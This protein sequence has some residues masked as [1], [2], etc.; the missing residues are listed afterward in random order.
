MPFSPT[1]AGT[2]SRR[3]LVQGVGA[4][5][6]LLTLAGCRSAVDD[7]KVA[8]AAGDGVPG[9]GGTLRV[10]ALIDHT[11]GLL[12]T[13]GSGFSLHRLIF[14]TLTRY[15]PGTL[16]PQPQLATAWRISPDGTEVKLTL[17]QGVTF[18]NGRPFTAD[19][20]V[21]AI[22]NLQNPQRSAQLR[23]TALAITGFD[24]VSPHELTLR[25][26]HPVANL[27]D[28][29]EF[30]IIAAKESVDGALQGG[31]PIGTGAFVWKS[32]TPGTSLTLDR[33]PNYWIPERPYLDGVEIRV[34]PQPDALLAALR[35]GQAHMSYGLGGRDL[36]SIE[37]D[38]AFVLQ[39][40]DQGAGNVYVGVNTAVAPFGDKRIRQA[41]SYAI[42]RD[43]IVKQALGGYGLAA[44]TPWPKSSP[45]F[46]EADAQR[47]PH[48]PARAKA[49]LA[50]AGHGNGLNVPLAYLGMQSAVAQM[51]QFDLDRIGV[52]TTLE[53]LDAAKFQAQ[54]IAQSMPALWV[55]THGFAANQPSTLAVSAYPFN[56]ARNTSKFS[57]PK[58]TEVVQRAWNQT[59]A[60][61]AAAKAAYTELGQVLLDEQFIIDIAVLSNV[62]PMATA[63]RDVTQSRYNATVFDDTY[64]AG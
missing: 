4:S 51:V 64:L 27:F 17:R 57:D 23:S 10:A 50:E 16:D 31:A 37:N 19:D 45:V 56:E 8:P 49:L 42:D 53:P 22:R 46:A 48:D 25:L 18:H 33:N 35:S 13:Q 28:L 44:A 30:M 26:A 7:G 6:A 58:Y 62:Q 47:Y 20:V 12:F 32:W 40:F 38:K 36:T 54:L 55:G 61:S 59:D 24:T 3:R 43:R 52:K 2:L 14:N 60:R 15:T 9:R 21:F 63:V 29:F 34:I 5:A 1:F 39:E 11:P 41:L